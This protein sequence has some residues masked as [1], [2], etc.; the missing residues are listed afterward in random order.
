[1]RTENYYVD[2]NTP[3]DVF[4]IATDLDGN[5]VSGSELTV[6]AARLEWKNIKGEWQEIPADI[7]ECKVTSAIRT[8]D[9]HLRNTYRRT[10]PDHRPGNR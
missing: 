4:L 2:R 7:Q 8:S 6:Q 1:M 3:I 5:A 9:L 10:L